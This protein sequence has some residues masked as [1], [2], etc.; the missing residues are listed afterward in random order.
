MWE[1]AYARA[2]Y[3]GREETHLIC[4][5]RKGGADRARALVGKEVQVVGSV[6][7]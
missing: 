3:Q 6:V 5:S 2:D 1:T 7:S 4:S